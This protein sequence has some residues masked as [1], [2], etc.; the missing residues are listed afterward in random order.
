MRTRR[1]HLVPSPT[2]YTI[3]QSAD[4]SWIGHAR[5]SQTAVSSGVSDQPTA[6]RALSALTRSLTIAHAA[7]PA[8][9]KA[10]A[11]RRPQATRP[12]AFTG[13]PT[14]TTP[15]GLP[16]GGG[17]GLPGGG[18]TRPPLTIFCPPA[19]AGLVYICCP[20][21]QRFVLTDVQW[22]SWAQ[23]EADL[24]DLAE[25]FLAGAGTGE[26]TDA[27]IAAALDYIAAGQPDALALAREDMCPMSS[28]F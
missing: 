15:T 13:L 5:N 6:R 4:G 1:K 25:Q 2:Q 21:G 27:E 8:I 16:G 18:G 28:D 17:T 9:R 22:D 19:P 23:R 11:A 10:L 24:T 26:M 20:G 14:L 7:S 12:R 3:T